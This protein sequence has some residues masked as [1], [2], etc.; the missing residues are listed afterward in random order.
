MRHVAGAVLLISGAAAET[1]GLLP[2][3]LAR[4]VLW[5][6]FNYTVVAAALRLWRWVLLPVA[7]GIAWLW[8]HAV[9][10]A[11]Y[12]GIGV[13]LWWAAFAVDKGLRWA[14]TALYWL[15]YYAVGKLRE[16]VGGVGCSQEVL[17]T[18]LDRRSAGPCG[19][20]GFTLARAF[21]GPAL[22]AIGFCITP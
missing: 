2:E 11:V 9:V 20:P 22:Q 15:I 8:A 19:G 6:L 17:D 7:H 13:P 12:Y 14:G 18:R 16:L 3:A 21:A 4:G 1:V 10:P 5:P